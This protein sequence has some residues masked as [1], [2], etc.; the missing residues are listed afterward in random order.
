MHAGDFLH[1]ERESG[2]AATFVFEPQVGTVPVQILE[3][4]G[5]FSVKQETPGLVHRSIVLPCEKLMDS[6]ALASAYVGLCSPISSGNSHPYVFVCGCVVVWVYVGAALWTTLWMR[7]GSTP[8]TWCV[9]SVG[10]G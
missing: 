7:A 4:M 6:V 3:D 8:M 1:Q 5:I 2:E 10:G 9:L